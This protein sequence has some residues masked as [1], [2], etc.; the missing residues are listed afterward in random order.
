MTTIDLAGV[1]RHFGATPV[2]QDVSLRLGPGVTGLLA[3]PGSARS[4]AEVLRQALTDPVKLEGCGERARDRIR[5]SALDLE[6]TV[7]RYT[8]IL[9]DVIRAELTSRAGPGR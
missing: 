1:S 6:S 3:E 5:G 7:A 4:L 9:G 2:L 8:E